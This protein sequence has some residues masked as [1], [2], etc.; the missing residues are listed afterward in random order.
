MEDAIAQAESKPASAEGCAQAEALQP[1]A[2]AA[3]E[4]VL[5]L[6]STTC[7]GWRNSTGQEGI[8][9][10]TAECTLRPG[11]EALVAIGRPD[12]AASVVRACQGLA[13]SLRGRP[14]RRRRPLLVILAIAEPA[15]S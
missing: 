13:G 14:C 8:A 6:R 7:M 3:G 12:E 5:T 9:S 15:L 4:E 2:R 1:L 10:A 11:A